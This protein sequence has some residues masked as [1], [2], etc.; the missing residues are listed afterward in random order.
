MDLLAAHRAAMH[1]FDRRVL[2]IADDQWANPTPDTEWSVRDLVEHLVGEQLWVPLLLGGATIE[3][4]GDRFDGDNLGTDPRT[5][6]SLAVTAARNAW[7]AP[8]AVNRTVHL[9]S[10][11]T[12][13]TDYAWQ[14][15]TDLTVHA[16][17]LARG[18]DA[19]DDLPAELCAAVLGYV[20]PLADSWREFGVF[21]AAVPVPADADT[22][23]TLLGL[24][25]RQR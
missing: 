3:E 15:I 23:T 2:L 6:W 14:M 21:A 16:W 25:G 17:D 4:V 8:G 5:A 12:P 19:D 18:I 1:E 11:D 24:L 13:A 7:L 9:S 10:G 22:Q 20:G